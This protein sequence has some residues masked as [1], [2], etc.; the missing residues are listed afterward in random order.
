MSALC[1]VQDCERDPHARGWCTLHY[2]RWKRHGDPIT[3][4]AEQRAPACA[5]DGCDVAWRRAGYC[6]AHYARLLRHGDVLAGGPSRAPTGQTCI[7][8]DCDRPAIAHGRCQRHHRTHLRA[9]DPRYAEQ[10]RAAWRRWHRR[11][12]PAVRERA[13]RWRDANEKRR[14]RQL[15][16]WK[17][18]NPWHASAYSYSKRRR[19]YGLPDVVAEQVIPADIYERD[20]GVCQLCGGHV[21]RA[22]RFPHPE[23]MT[24]DH[25]IPVSDPA[26]E[27]TYANVQL[28]HWGCN[29]D[30]Q[31]APLA[32]ATR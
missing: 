23:A 13:R 1:S 17:Q 15:M 7:D 31:T 28:A 26:S 2:Q 8:T 16:A 27:H 19:I 3:V 9:T 29:R 11:N 22:L 10:R 4:L 25:R 12:A 14:F 5:V 24:L 20:G 30:R 6:G 21:D 18:Q 32:E